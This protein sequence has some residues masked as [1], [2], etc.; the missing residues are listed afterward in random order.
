LRKYISLLRGINVSGQ[1]KIKMVDLKALY[2]TLGFTDVLT[3]IQSGNVIFNSEINDKF[4]LIAKL[5]EA[6]QT[7]YGF[8]VPVQICTLNDLNDVLSK[9]PFKGL[10]VD[11]DGAKVYISFLSEKPATEKV[12][13]LQTYVVEPEK[14]I[15]NDQT[16][17]LYCPNGYGR[18][19]LSNT[20]IEKKLGVAATTRN[21]RTARKLSDLAMAG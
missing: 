18:T 1:K 6:V 21:L 15:V 9:L 19:K 7:R 2:E 13:V 14:L 11:E 5:E 4:E 8:H 12:P 17:Y 16:V 3:Y 20:F 10:N